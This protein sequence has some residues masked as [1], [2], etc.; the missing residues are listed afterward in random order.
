MDKLEQA[1]QFGIEF[2]IGEHYGGADTPTLGVD[3]DEPLNGDDLNIYD[4]FANVMD[5]DYNPAEHPEDETDV[6][7]IAAAWETGYRDQWQI[8]GMSQML[9]GQTDQNPID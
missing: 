6:L 8:I 3:G 7:D 5:R 4:V 1:T 2:A 9:T